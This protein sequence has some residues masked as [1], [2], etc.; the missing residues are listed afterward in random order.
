MISLLATAQDAAVESDLRSELTAHGYDIRQ[1][2]PSQEDIL[3]VVLSRAALQDA[4]VQSA[5]D[6]ALDRGQHIIPTLAE[7]VRLP[8]LI[9]HLTP[10]DL[11]AANATEQLYAQIGAALSPDARLP[12]RVRTPSVQRSNRRS[13]LIV[14][15]L[16]LAMFLIGLYAVAV[17]NIEA[18]VE[19]Y[20]QVNTEA[21]ATRD[22]IIGPTLESYLQFLPGSVEEAEQYPAT[23]E[24]IPTRLRPF[25]A[26]TAT[27]VAADQQGG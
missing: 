19:E 11:S 24:A 2:A 1:A 15:V 5:I 6:T 3:V 27:A 9:D 8:K 20:N 10:V 22:I 18:P 7:P 12:L 4:A 17:L 23:L 21:A 13:G 26:L 16:A 14:G 25:A